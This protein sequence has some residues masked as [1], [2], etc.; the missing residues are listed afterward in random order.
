[1]AFID[2]RPSLA[3]QLPPTL[4]TCTQIVDPRV[5]QIARLMQ[6]E[7]KDQSTLPQLAQK[8]NLTPEHLCRIFARNLGF[9]PL[10]YRKL[11][12]LQKASVLLN[13]SELSIKQIMFAVGLADES[14][15]V[16]DFE[17]VFGLSPI[18]YR[19][20]NRLQSRLIETPVG[21]P[22]QTEES[23]L[24]NGNQNQPIQGS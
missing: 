4:S 24:A 12:R 2:Y 18:R 9:S 10:K 1:M 23:I 13:E 16:R 14:H 20:S 17:K 19:Q 5:E 8:V 7:F 21:P 15:F 22:L 3:Q 6:S 11:C